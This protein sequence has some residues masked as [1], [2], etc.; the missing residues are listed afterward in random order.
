MGIVKNFATFQANR[1]LVSHYVVTDDD[2]GT[3]L[4]GVTFKFKKGDKLTVT[5]YPH[6]GS[7]AVVN[8]KGRNYHISASDIQIFAKRQN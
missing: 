4:M 6:S 2:E 1:C 3:D 5:D 8:H 7:S